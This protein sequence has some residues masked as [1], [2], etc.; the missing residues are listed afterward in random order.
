MTWVKLTDTFA[1]DPRLEEAGADAAIV[2]VAG[3]C[4]CSRQLTDGTIPAKSAR[5]LWS[6]N[7]I[8]QAIAALVTAGLWTEVDG[9]YAIVNY[10]EDQPSAEEVRHQQQLK[11]DRMRRWREKKNGVDA[12]T[13]ASQDGPR[14]ASRDASPPRPAPPRKGGRG[15]G[16]SDGA[17]APPPAPQE[18]DP[19]PFHL[20]LKQ[21]W[22]YDP[23]TT[24]SQ[25]IGV[26]KRI[27]D[28]AAEF[29]DTYPDRDYGLG[30]NEVFPHVIANY[31]SLPGD[32]K[33]QLIDFVL[34][35]D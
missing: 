27:A 19:N 22:T 32:E 25:R 8:D 33:N 23:A 28:L 34:R 1:D 16:L 11:A 17:D 4:W 18:E 9:G 3:L 14:D 15:G 6:V 31:N 21:R 26:C 10:L 35:E 13:D 30:L 29:D 5:R 20:W 2:H 12:S 24:P 7:D